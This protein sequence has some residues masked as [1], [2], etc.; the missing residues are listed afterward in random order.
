ML[1]VTG[2]TGHLGRG[3]VRHL[4]TRVPTARICGSIRDPGKAAELT[5]L[6]VQ[7]RHGDFAEPE[8]L[9]KAF[10]GAEQ[11][12]IVSADKLGEEA[13]T[14]HRAAIAAAR[15][16]GARRILYTSHMGA[17]E[18]SPF[19]PAA[20]H[21]HTEQ[22]LDTCSVPF[23][24]LRHGFYAESCLRMV[25]D[26]LK[27]GELRVPQDGPV[28]WT[29]RADL[30]EADAAILASEG[31]W[32][33]VTPPLTATEAV[34]MADIAAMASDVLGREVRHTIV[35]DEDWVTVTIEAGVPAIYAKML[36]GVF[37]AARQGDFAAT[38]PALRELL[39][40]DP[41]SMRDVVASCV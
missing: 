7:V 32:D 34:T 29:A 21:W 2:A 35:P 31:E 37:R 38:D 39:G 14:L 17:R 40:R 19:A 9:V 3:I 10:S 33:G 13:R 27:T 23:T 41:K 15:K 12:L 1:I 28:S 11:V 6:G 25:G 30:A 4:S 16:A 22:D 36:L 18:D 5:D 8:S 24:A 26:Q 20:Q